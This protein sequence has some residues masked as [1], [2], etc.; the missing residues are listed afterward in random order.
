MID[1]VASCGR[2]GTAWRRSTPVGDSIASRPPR[3][4]GRGGYTD[5]LRQHH[6]WASDAD[7]CSLADVVGDDISWSSCVGDTA[8]NPAAAMQLCRRLLCQRLTPHFRGSPCHAGCRG[9]GG[10]GARTLTCR[11]KMPD[12]SRLAWHIRDGYAYAAWFSSR[13]IVIFQ[14]HTRTAVMSRIYTDRWER[15]IDDCTSSICS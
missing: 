7:D 15:S 8:C 6:V 1:T 4:T 3:T 2:D 10:G 9:G 11:G 12:V 14:L 13:E 5:G